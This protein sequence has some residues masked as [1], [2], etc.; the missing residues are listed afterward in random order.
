MSDFRSPSAMTPTRDK[1]CIISMTPP[2]N[3]RKSKAY[4]TSKLSNKPSSDSPTEKTDAEIIS[5]R[6]LPYLS[7]SRPANG[8]T[9]TSAELLNPRRIPVRLA[10][11]IVI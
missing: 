1:S 8:P 11:P 3:A 6:S 10:T 2:V 7:E 9:K 5:V 4:M